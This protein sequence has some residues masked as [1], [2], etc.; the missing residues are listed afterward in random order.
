M[1]QNNP[2][3][4][5]SANVVK[6][7]AGGAA[8]GSLQ[9]GINGEYDFNIGDVISEAWN[10]TSG[11]KG[12]FWGA[13]IIIMA[14]VFA[15]V[16]ALS[17][18]MVA[19]GGQQNQPGVLARII[20][21]LVI[22]AVMYPLMAGILMMGVRRSVNLPISF[23]LAFSYFGYTVPVVVAAI[24]VTIM[25]A[26]GF[27]LLVIPGIYLSWAYMLTVPLIVEKKLGPWQAME[28]SRRAITHH[29]F[30][31]FFLF[32]LMFLILGVS[33]I[34]LGLGLIWTYPMMVNIVG[35]LYRDIFGVEEARAA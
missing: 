17:V 25:T 2:Y 11:L 35:I 10:K 7:A 8:G 19:M 13:S 28:A 14:I 22:T 30:K 16:I 34:P 24:L 4:T 32:I 1:N 27:A 23:N 26:I 9:G 5:P 15:V 33:M 29:W 20:I 12:P 18:T 31:V 6:K 21:Q 3:Q